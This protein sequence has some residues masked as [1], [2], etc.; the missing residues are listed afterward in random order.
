MPRK[1][2]G[3]GLIVVLCPYCR[4]YFSLYDLSSKHDREKYSGSPLP[5]KH[6]SQYDVRISED[7]IV[8][9]PFCGAPLSIRPRK[10]L[11]MPIKKFKEIAYIDR[12]S[13][14][15]IFYK[16]VIAKMFPEVFSNVTGVPT[17]IAEA[18]VSLEEHGESTDS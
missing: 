14:T 8:K 16:D 15:V 7:G 10:F 6:L 13:R 5:R 17:S 9:C 1:P 11:V 2:S 12:E 4:K 18:D 3:Q